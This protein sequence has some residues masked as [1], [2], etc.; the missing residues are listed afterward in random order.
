MPISFQRFNSHSTD[1]IL[2][3]LVARR[4]VA[5]PEELAQLSHHAAAAPFATDLLEVDPALWGGFWHF[6]VI[7]PGYRLP[8]DE[9]ALLRATRLDRHWP[10]NTT[11]EAFIANLHRAIF[12]PQ[13]GIWTLEVA[14]VPC[15]VFAAGAQRPSSIGQDQNL[16]TLGWYCAATGRLHAGYRT[17]YDPSLNFAGAVQQQ[18]LKPP[19]VCKSVPSPNTGWI[20]Q[21]VETDL[22]SGHTLA[23]RLDVEILRLRC[24]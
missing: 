16:I 7:S 14:G 10:L 5:T 2:C 9:L 17:P 4:A 23:E 18:K 12:F 20:N 22:P 13:A 19:P 1:T 21:A 6:D 8:A 3:D 24:G 15:A 11:L